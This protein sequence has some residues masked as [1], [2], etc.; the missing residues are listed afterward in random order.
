M[1][2][3]IRPLTEP[4]RTLCANFNRPHLMGINHETLLAPLLYAATGNSAWMMHFDRQ[5]ADK[6]LLI[7]FFLIWII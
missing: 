7:I 1:G 4:D 3:R 5:S 6:H 2:E